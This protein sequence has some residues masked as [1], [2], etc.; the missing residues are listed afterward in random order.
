MSTRE[1]RLR[2]DKID[3]SLVNL[4]DAL[5]AT[6]QGVSLAAVGGYG[7][8]ELSPGSDLDLIFIHRSKDQR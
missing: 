1:R 3:A 5:G 6:S 2:S 7:R 8:G 4:F